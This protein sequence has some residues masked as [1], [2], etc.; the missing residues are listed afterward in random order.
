ML[1][2]KYAAPQKLAITGKSNG[3]LLTTA[4]LT[5]APEIFG[6]VVSSVPLTDMLRYP[7]HR[8]G[9]LWRGEYG[10]PEVREE[11]LN[12]YN[13]SPYHRVVKGKSYPPS[14]ITTALRNRRVD[15]LHSR[16]M[17][18]MLQHADPEGALHLLSIDEH[19]GHIY[20]SHLNYARRVS[21][22]HGFLMQQL[23]VELE[24]PKTIPFN[25]KA[26]KIHFFAKLQKEQNQP[27]S[28]NTLFQKQSHMNCFKKWK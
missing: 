19:S 25:L 16:K 13:Y 4:A 21:K 23:G 2:S 8:L 10:S 27:V 11:C 20:P 7:H 14:L 5:Q 24:I 18:A 26:R 3:G 15:P 12:L 9:T 28:K 1:I 17:T 22:E 6:A